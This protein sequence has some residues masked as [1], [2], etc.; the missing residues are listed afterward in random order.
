MSKFKRDNFNDI[1]NRYSG[2]DSDRLLDI[3]LGKTDYTPKIIE[4]EVV[5]YWSTE[6]F[7]YLSFG[8]F[9]S[10]NLQKK[11]KNVFELENV[12]KD[13]N[14]KAEDIL[15][16]D[17]LPWNID[18]KVLRGIKELLEINSR[19]FIDA[20]KEHPIP[21]EKLNPNKFSSFAARTTNKLSSEERE[22][23]LEHSLLKVALEK[24]NR[25]REKY[26]KEL[27]NN[28]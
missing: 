18:Y 22:E 9:I 7:S 1:F 13:F 15:D 12:V 4:E 3:A 25:R 14:Y 23:E 24:E 27:Q 11:N 21:E 17:V 26:L 19:V 10:A 20:I 28:I 16:D 2:V 6:D 8:Q 5:P